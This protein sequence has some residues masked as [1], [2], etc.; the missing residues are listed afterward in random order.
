VLITFE[1]IDGCGKS[2]QAR[3]LSQR[4]KIEGKDILLLR[5]PGGTDLSEQ[6]R[7]I[8][9]NKSFSQPLTREAELLLF[10]ASRAQL[11]S[12]V[13]MPALKKNTTV[14]LDR[15]TDSTIAY[16]GFGRGISL[17]HIKHI[18]SIATGNLEPNIT[19]FLDIPLEVA[20][21]RRSATQNDRIEAEQNEF[22]QKVMEGYWYLAQQHRE[23]IRVINGEDSVEEIA[24]KIWEMMKK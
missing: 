11:V 8:L 10:A 7:N 12:E 22:H 18:N 4:L 14:I 24:A 16:Q 6:V 17:D 3:L 5:E 2:T 21:S 9:L 1:G 20:M 13:I 23:R 15:F 19:F